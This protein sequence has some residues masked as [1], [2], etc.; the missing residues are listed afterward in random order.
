VRH[1]RLHKAYNWHSQVLFRS[2]PF[3]LL[4]CLFRV[5]E[6]RERRTEHTPA[7]YSFGFHVPNGNV[8]LESWKDK[9]IQTRKSDFEK[10]L[11]ESTHHTYAARYKAFG[12]KG[13]HVR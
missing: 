2:T 4:G 7:I 10:W 9:D 3:L 12:E 6:A 8:F 13:A 5:A 11:V 1:S